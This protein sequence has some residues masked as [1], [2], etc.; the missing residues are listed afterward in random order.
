MLHS[1]GM[2]GLT[3][4]VQL[5]ATPTN[6]KHRR[7]IP[8]ERMPARRTSMLASLS[9]TGTLNESAGFY[10]CYTDSSSKAM[11]IARMLQY[12]QGV[13]NAG[14]PPNAQ[15]YAMQVAAPLPIRRPVRRRCDFCWGTGA[16]AAKQCID[17]DRRA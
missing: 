5:E 9:C 7:L 8:L 14:P 6:R 17:G 4:S 3:S 15:L 16:L 2:L 12:L 10:T 13:A 1:V 11:P